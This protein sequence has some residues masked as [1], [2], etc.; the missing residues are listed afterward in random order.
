MFGINSKDSLSILLTTE[1]SYVNAKKLAFSI[2]HT[3]YAAC[4]SFNK[5]ESIYWWEGEIQDS[6]EVQL[7]IKTKNKSIETLINFIQKK[8]SYK[9]PEFLFWDVKSTFDYSDWINKSI[10]IKDIY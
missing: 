8:H 7:V 10:D 3:K 5:I 6:E 4:I 9:N 2:L 1:S